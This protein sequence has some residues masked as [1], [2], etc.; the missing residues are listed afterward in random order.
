ME[1]YFTPALQEYMKAKKKD[2]VVVEFVEVSSGDFDLSELY[3]H[4]T[5]RKQAEFF[6]NKKHYRPVSTQWGTVLL[7]RF[8]L[9]FSETVTFDLK[10]LLCFRSIRYDGIKV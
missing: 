8:P 7:P 5:D 2:T 6:V 9:T 1:F 10:K 4:L 3:V